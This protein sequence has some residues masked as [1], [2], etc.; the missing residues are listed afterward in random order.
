[1]RGGGAYFKPLHGIEFFTPETEP[2]WCII[3][4]Q[5]PNLGKRLLLLPPS[6]STVSLQPRVVYTERN[7]KR[8]PEISFLALHVKPRSD[9]E[10]DEV[11]SGA[12]Y[13]ICHLNDRLHCKQ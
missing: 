13:N 9:T 7:W 2:I 8:H 1:M 11:F 6:R 10:Y 12:K 4:G 5:L 3:F